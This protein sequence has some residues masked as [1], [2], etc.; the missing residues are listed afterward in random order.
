MDLVEK[1]PTSFMVK[2]LH[3]KLLLLD[4]LDDIIENP[5]SKI[6]HKLKNSESGNQVDLMASGMTNTLSYDDQ[7]L[8]VRLS[9]HTQDPYSYQYI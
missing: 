5:E 3:E 6:L 7:V 2:R 8:K 1:T 4:Y 9:K